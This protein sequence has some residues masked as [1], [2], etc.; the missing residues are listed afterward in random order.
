MFGIL[1]SLVISTLLL[2]L[3]AHRLNATR[4]KREMAERLNI[5]IE[6]HHESEW[7]VSS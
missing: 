7:P 6:E 2:W 1:I 3:A 5:V 4:R